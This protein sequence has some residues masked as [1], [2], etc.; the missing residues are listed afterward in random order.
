MQDLRDWRDS[1]W[2]NAARRGANC[3][4]ELE[5]QAWTVIRTFADGKKE[6][7]TTIMPREG[8]IEVL[9]HGRNFP[10]YSEVKHV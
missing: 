2:W 9:W 8:D 7:I 6:L 10:R 5:L 4:Q 3:S 1:D